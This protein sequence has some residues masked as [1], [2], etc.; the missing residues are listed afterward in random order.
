VSA[1]LR[2]GMIGHLDAQR[3]LLHVRPLLAG[4]LRSPPVAVD[5]MS[6]YSPAVEIAAMRHE[7]QDS[8]FFAN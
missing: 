2:L 6:A 3:V 5:G 4:L 7:V 8:R 1:A